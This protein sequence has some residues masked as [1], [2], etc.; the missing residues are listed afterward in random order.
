MLRKASHSI[1]VCWAQHWPT[2]RQALRQALDPC[3]PIPRDTLPWPLV[4]V[5]PRQQTS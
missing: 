1:D 5:R 2:P 4:L 3:L